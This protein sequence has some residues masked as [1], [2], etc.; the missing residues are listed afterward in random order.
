MRHILFSNSEKYDIAVLVKSS[1]FKKRELEENYIFP[2]T[3]QGVKGEMIAFTLEYPDNGKL[4]VKFAKDYLSELIPVLNELGVKMLY[5]TDGTYFKLLTGQTKA[6]PHY[7]YVLPCAVKGYEHMSVVLGLNYQALIFNPDLKSKLDLS[8]QTLASGVAGSYIPIGQN[9][10]HSSDHPQEVQDVARALQSLHQYPELTCDIEAFSLSF[11]KAGVGTIGFAWDEHNGISFPVDYCE[12]VNQEQ[13]DQGYFGSFVPCHAKRA[14]LRQFF[15]DYQ[16]ELT[17]HNGSYDVKVMIYTLWMDSL[18]DTKGLLN[19]LAVLTRNMHDTKIITYLATNSTADNSLKLK[20]LAHEFAGNWAM[21][22]I[23][24]IRRIKLKDLLKYN[25]IDALCTWFVK[26]KY[27]PIMVQSNQLELYKGLM[28]DSVEL[29]IQIELTGM[30]LS[31]TKVQEVKAEL[32]SI[33]QSEIDIIMGSQIVK[34]F[35]ND[36]RQYEWEKDYEARK[37]KAKNPGKIFPK[38][39]VK[40]AHIE[41][42]PNSGP[43]LQKLLYTKMGLPVIDLTD[44]KLPAT[45]ADTIEKLRNHCTTP[46]Q[47]ELLSALIGLGKVGIILSTFIPAFENAIEKGTDDIVWLHGNLNLGATVSGRL[48]S[49]DPNLQNIPAGSRYGKLIKECFVSPPGWIFAGADFNS[50]E[51]YISALT[52]KDPAKLAVYERGFDGHCLR[53]SYYFRD[54]LPHID[55]DDPKSVNSIKKDY[56]SLR[57]DSKAPTFLLTYGG[58]YHGMMKNLGWPE[59]K[60]K[61]IEA[62]YHELYK[63]SDAFIQNRLMQA[64]KD[65]YVD[66][67]FGLRVRTPLL[68]QVVFG[69]NT[70]PYEAAA[71]GRTA[72]NAMGQSYGLLNNRAAAAFMKKVRASKYRYDILPVVLI[73]DAIYLLIRDDVEVVAWVNKHLIDEMKWQELPEIQHPTVKLGAALDLFYPSWAHKLTLPNGADEASIRKMC[74]EHLEEIK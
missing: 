28:L 39:I 23:K 53:A 16:G 4:S 7:G 33:K 56:E 21:D 43:Q 71:E 44:T 37:S 42:N 54:Q 64:C 69:S 36:L 34:E 55:Q 73:H 3:T 24:D 70:M 26:K 66:V 60:A 5:V 6:E 46:E 30:P 25:L 19:G 29:L 14:A 32:N 38:P 22:E 61:A 41:L 68:K 15:E 47:K 8:L 27:W 48:S 35:N 67:A 63:V 52:T 10:I 17:F 72:A 50:L 65:G 31:K 58:T 59:D 40:F 51:D 9:L 11:D 74:A 12:E 2:L 62:G 13:I 20:S 57:Q 49:S 18:T 1:L 45:G